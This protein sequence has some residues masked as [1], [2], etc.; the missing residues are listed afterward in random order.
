MSF[1][2]PAAEARDAVSRTIGCRPPA[3]AAV[4]PNAVLHF[5][6][7][8]RESTVSSRTFERL[9]LW[10]IALLSS[11]K[12]CRPRLGVRTATG[13]RNFLPRMGGAHHPP[14]HDCVPIG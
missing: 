10:L 5:M 4:P 9:I 6:K 13:E 7:L 14:V 12:R 3:S 2:S 1:A 8:R 11:S